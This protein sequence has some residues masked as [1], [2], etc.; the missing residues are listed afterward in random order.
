MRNPIAFVLPKASLELIN[1]IKNDT[2][3]TIKIII[4]FNPTKNNDVVILI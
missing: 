2:I 4:M 3:A 1:A